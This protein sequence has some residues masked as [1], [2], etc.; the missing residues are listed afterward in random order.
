[1]DKG[2]LGGILILSSR[3]V[4]VFMS[5]RNIIKSKREGKFYNQASIFASTWAKRSRANESLNA[6][7]RERLT[8]FGIVAVGIKPF[9]GLVRLTEEK[10]IGIEKRHGAI[11]KALERVKPESTPFELVNPKA[12]TIGK[13][14]I[15]EGFDKPTVKGL[16]NFFSSQKLKGKRPFP[17]NRANAQREDYFLA[18]K[19]AFDPLHKNRITP[20]SLTNAWNEFLNFCE[21]NVNSQVPTQESVAVVGISPL[22][23]IR[24]AIV[25]SAEDEAKERNVQK[26]IN[27]Q[28]LSAQRKKGQQELE[29]LKLK[30][31]K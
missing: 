22:G 1:M 20:Q 16:L 2:D 29:L 10:W 19:F 5:P 30:K 25:A 24:F 9:R 8:P 31:R 4:N 17:K 21:T 3:E 26:Q 18:K 28:E 6:I 15:L 27:A 11:S 23:K 12:L 7:R 13:Q 14:S